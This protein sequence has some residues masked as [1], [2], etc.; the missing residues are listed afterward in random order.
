LIPAAFF[1]WRAAA[2]APAHSPLNASAAPPRYVTKSIED[3]REG[4]FVLARDEFGRDLG[5]KRVTEV[6][7]RVSD[8]LRILTFRAADGTEQTLKTTDEHP[9]WAESRQAWIEAKN[10]EVGDTLIGPR[11][12]LQTLT[13]TAYEAHPEGIPVF[14]FRVEDYH[15]YFVRDMHV[16]RFPLLVHNAEYDE[17]LT[18]YA[19]GKESVSRLQRLANESLATPIP[20]PSVRVDLGKLTRGWHDRRVTMDRWPGV[21]DQG[22]ARTHS[23]IRRLSAR[24]R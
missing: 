3:V 17:T 16:G 1:F 18:R 12:E 24:F 6:Y 20:H 2:S 5:M 15:S 4:D 13:E 8:H 10:I 23:T 9:F 19:G 14:N 11:G 22:W 21:E 7:R